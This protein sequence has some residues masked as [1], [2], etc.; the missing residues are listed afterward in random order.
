MSEVASLCRVPLCIS[1]DEPEHEPVQ[2]CADQ[3][4]LNCSESPEYRFLHALQYTF[5]A[6][7]VGG[8]PAVTVVATSPSSTLT[9]LSSSKQVCMQPHCT[10]SKLASL[11]LKWSLRCIIQK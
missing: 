7:P 3:Y 5:T 1:A 6:T 11:C 10:Q 2:P 4:M 9:G 8:G